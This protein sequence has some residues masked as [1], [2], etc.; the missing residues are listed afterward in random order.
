MGFVT[1]A[2]LTIGKPGTLSRNTQGRP[3]AS[4]EYLALSWMTSR[5][6]NQ[7][8]KENEP[9]YF[10]ELKEDY[11]VLADERQGEVGP[12]THKVNLPNLVPDTVTQ[13]AAFEL[14]QATEEGLRAASHDFSTSA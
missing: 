14:N 11:E 5:S 12:G 7:R 8:E 2:L 13:L 6:I 9:R 1:T 4:I 3:T 10:S